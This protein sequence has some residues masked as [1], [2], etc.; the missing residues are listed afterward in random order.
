MLT[1]LAIGVTAQDKSDPLL[2]RPERTNYEETSRLEDVTA[3]LAALSA[4]SPL[5]R[6][7]TFGTSEEGRAMPPVTLSSPAVARP[8]DKPAGRPV[9]FLLANQHPRRLGADQTLE[10]IDGRPNAR[11]Q[12]VELARHVA[13]HLVDQ[14]ANR[15][16]RVILRYALLRRR[17]TEHRI[18]LAV[19]SSHGRHGSTRSTICR[20]QS[21]GYS[22]IERRKE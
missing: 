5:V 21:D 15:T 2:T 11:I 12:A 7:Q 17:A 14:R 3:F 9:V 1:T 13:Q 18:G 8:A 10:G 16:E 19:V 6:V 20:S 22:A 4:K